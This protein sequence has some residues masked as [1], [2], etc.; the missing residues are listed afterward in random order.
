MSRANSTMNERDGEKQE[1]VSFF[2]TDTVEKSIIFEM[3]FVEKP[4]LQ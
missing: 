3:C 2:S 1:K 4:Q